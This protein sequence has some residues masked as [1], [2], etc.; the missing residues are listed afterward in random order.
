MGD[1]NRNRRSGGGSR[2]G[3]GGFRGRDSGPREMFSAVCDEC[4]NNCEVPFR[5]SGDKPIYCSNCFEKRDGG[6]GRRENRGGARR[7]GFEKKDNSSKQLLEQMTSLNMKLDRILNVL[8][9]RSKKTK[10]SSK[11]KVKTKKV[12]KKKAKKS[13]KKA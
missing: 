10:K 2:H 1:F 7:G 4:G 9:S 5:P 13:S 12:G 6:G 11:G 8:E 3:G